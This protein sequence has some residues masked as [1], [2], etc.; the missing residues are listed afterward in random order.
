MY[1]PC[2]ENKGADQLRR[3][4]ATGLHPCFSIC[5]N[6]GSLD[7]AHFMQTVITVATRICKSVVE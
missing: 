7:A 4:R 5:K 6:R 3:Y 1:Y 2:S